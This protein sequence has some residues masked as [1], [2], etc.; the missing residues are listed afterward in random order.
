[1]TGIRRLRSRASAAAA[2]RLGQWLR[3]PSP[4]TKPDVRISRRR[5]EGA[6][7][8]SGPSFPL[9]RKYR[10]FFLVNTTS[11]SVL[12]RFSDPVTPWPSCQKS[13]ATQKRLRPPANPRLASRRAARRRISGC[14]AF[15]FFLASESVP[16]RSTNFLPRR[17]DGVARKWRRNGLKRLNPR[18]EMVVARKPGS[19][20][21]WYTGAR[22]TVRSGREPQERCRIRCAGPEGNFPPRKALKSLETE[23]ESGKPRR[24]DEQ[25]GDRAAP[26]LPR[27]R[28]ARA[29]PRGAGTGA[30][31]S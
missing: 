25:T 6:A 14:G 18:P 21:I 29:D 27:W 30:V 8:A 24:R 4:L 13:P 1:M 17:Q 26:P 11:A 20:N 15:A 12:H 10:F 19:H 2:S 22:L 9:K 23:L 28:A 31:A 3:F 7:A 5:V 16:S